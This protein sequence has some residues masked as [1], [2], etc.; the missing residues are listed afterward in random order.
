MPINIDDGVQKDIEA[1]HTR[2][3]QIELGF[4]LFELALDL[5]KK[6]QLVAAYKTYDALFHIDIV[7]SHYDEEPTFVRGVQNGSATDELAFLA[8]NVK[9]LRYLV[10]RNRA[11]LYLDIL[12]DPCVADPAILNGDLVA[13]K[14]KQLFYTIIDDF[15]ICWLYQHPDE[16]VLHTLYELLTFVECPKLARYVLEFCLNAESE[17]DDVFVLPIDGIDTAYK[18][19]VADL[20]RGL[21]VYPQLHDLERKYRFL[22]PIKQDLHLQIS[23][24]TKSNVVQINVGDISWDHVID[25]I[26]YGIKLVQESK[27]E[28]TTLKLKHIDPYTFTP[29]PLDKVE[30]LIQ[31]PQLVNSSHVTLDSQVSETVDNVSPEPQV[32]PEIDSKL[33]KDSQSLSKVD[34]DAQSL[35]VKKSIQRASKRLQKLEEI[36]LPSIDLVPLM[37]AETTAFFRE[38]NNHLKLVQENND[39][40]LVGDVVDMFLN[41][42]QTYIKDFVDGINTLEAAKYQSLKTGESKASDERL[43]LLEVLRTFG[44]KPKPTQLNTAPH[45]TPHIDNTVNSETLTATLRQINGGHYHINHVKVHVLHQLLGSY[46]KCLITD[47]LWPD[48]MYEAVRQWIVQLEPQLVAQTLVCNNLGFKVSVYEILVDNYISKHRAVDSAISH[49]YHGHSRSSKAALTSQTAELVKLRYG[50]KKWRFHIEQII[51]DIKQTSATVSE[52]VY[53]AIIRF[54]W[55]V[56]HQENIDN[57]DFHSS[58]FIRLLLN[59]L[60]GLFEAHPHS[61]TMPNYKNI[62]PLS[63]GVIKDLYNTVTVLTMF[64]KIVYGNETSDNSEAVT[65]LETTLVDKGSDKVVIDSDKVAID[66]IKQFL[67]NSIDMKLNLWK[68]LFLYYHK[69]NDIAKV[70]FGFDTSLAM[71]LR[72]LQGPYTDLSADQR[73]TTLL[74]IISF[75]DQHLVIY[76]Q[77]LSQ[78]QWTPQPNIDAYKHMLKML[79]VFYLFSLHEEACFLTSQRTTIAQGSVAVY[80]WFKNILVR[81]ITLVI[82]YF[83]QLVGPQ[84]SETVYKLMSL[85]HH[86]LGDRQLC[87]SGDCIFLQMLQ[88]T[89]LTTSN[90]NETLQIIACRYNCRLAIDEFVPRDHYPDTV[91]TFSI[92]VINQLGKLVLSRYSLTNPPKGDVKQLLDRFY[93]VVGDPDVDL[94]PLSHNYG[95]VSQFLASTTISPRFMKEC[96]YGLHRLAL[97]PVHN[98]VVDVVTCGLYFLQAVVLFGSYKVRKKAMQSRSIELETITR[99]LEHDLAYGNHRVESWILLGEVYSF[100]VEDELIWTS[101]KLIS[102]DRKAGTANLQRKALLCYFTA[103]SLRSTTKTTTELLFSQLSS[104]LFNAITSPMDSMALKVLDHPPPMKASTVNHVI[105]SLYLRIIQQCLHVTINTNPHLWF[106][107][108]ILSKVQGKLGLAPDIVFDTLLKAVACCD[109][110]EPHYRLCSVAYKAVKAGMSIKSGISYVHSDAMFKTIDA[111]SILEYRLFC[112]FIIKCLRKIEIVDKKRW[113]HKYRYRMAK[114]YFQDLNQLEKAREEMSTIVV[115][116]PAA[117]SLVLIWKPDFE[118][119][120]KHFFYSYQYVLLFI[121]ILSHE[122]NLTALINMVPRLRR[123]SSIMISLNHVWS[124]CCT[125]ICNLIRN[126]LN[127]T[128]SLTETFLSTP[129]DEYV[130]HSQIVVETLKQGIPKQL[131]FHSA[132]LS[133]LNDMKKLNNGFG[134]TALIDDTI[135]AVYIRIYEAFPVPVKNGPEV[136]KIDSPNGKIKRLA[137]KDIYPVVNDIL[138]S[139]R[140]IDAIM[141]ERPEIFNEFIRTNPIGN[142][143][144]GT[145]A[146]STPAISHP[147]INHLHI[148]SH[149]AIGTPPIGTHSTSTH[150]TN[151]HLTGTPPTSTHPVDETSGNPNNQ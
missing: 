139:K 11:F 6:R 26:N 18:T 15:G 28:S 115:I 91:A 5:H 59:E 23:N 79:E 88:D 55:C 126:S 117:K 140:D 125:V 52:D 63:A 131:S 80:N 27:P 77:H 97:L 135:C 72:Y 64:A 60:Q 129:Y 136:I 106:N 83:S 81:T 130:V 13:D 85:V 44:T 99:L 39:P 78:H 102:P 19:L 133:A 142:L 68:I 121:D 20:H 36:S 145:P 41:P 137:K 3:L 17:S 113:H 31:D 143:P 56:V 75:Y 22:L 2:E 151:T 132:I 86:Q 34:K 95:V 30:F 92:P 141:K 32:L 84:N 90:H 147:V 93:D 61:R 65:L 122:N 38:T 24:F 4:Q 101:D 110:L 1:D 74:K 96:F 54:Q 43:K 105:P 62:A 25:A 21:S 108:Y 46:P 14:F 49:N 51:Y 119:P 66:S 112:H 150:T 134:Q 35:S 76:L 57:V 149:P 9:N 124:V 138:K 107:Y 111:P 67:D 100:L 118:R 70:Q 48:T 146:I 103:V 40:I 53:D 69:A 12:Q 50:L 98:D 8:P 33:D 128:K 47:T 71:V 42:A 94:M 37:F 109:T 89:F 16:S 148:N 120:G 127:V 73:M 104:E 144:I 58:E 123:S 7:A 114:I 87:D 45:T 116:K 82:V 10:F 29:E